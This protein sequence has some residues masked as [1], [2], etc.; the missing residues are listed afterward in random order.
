M[1]LSNLLQTNTL[2]DK[3]G[4]GTTSS[5]SIENLLGNYFQNSYPITSSVANTV[6]NPSQ[7]N[8]QLN[9]LTAPKTQNLNETDQ[10]GLLTIPNNS[11]PAILRFF[12]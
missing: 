10:T 2:Y 5:S 6:I 9:N 4:N 1:G 3:T 7:T 8:N 11:L 12:A